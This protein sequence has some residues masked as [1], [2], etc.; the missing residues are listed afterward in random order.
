M[1]KSLSNVFQILLPIDKDCLLFSVQ[2]VIESLPA[3]EENVFLLIS[4]EENGSRDQNFSSFLTN[5]HVINT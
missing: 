4:E 3:E 1:K 2:N 5:L